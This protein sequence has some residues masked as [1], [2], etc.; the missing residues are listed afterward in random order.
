MLKAAPTPSPAQTA[1]PT[2]V[3]AMS[4]SELEKKK[5]A[6]DA[7]AA[8]E[9][10]EDAKFEI[11]PEEAKA[12]EKWKADPWAAFVKGIHYAFTTWDAAQI[13]VMQ[14]FV[15]DPEERLTVIEESVVEMFQQKSTLRFYDYIM[16]W[17]LWPMQLYALL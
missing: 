17:P 16:L 6:E 1:A 5:A 15:E 11:T 9:A 14:E 4:Q 8:A 12:W 3:Y 13:A 10:A 7:K 2:V